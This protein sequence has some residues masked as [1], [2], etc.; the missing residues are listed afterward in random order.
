MT[1]MDKGLAAIFS[2]PW[3]FELI[4]QHASAVFAAAT[5]PFPI[6]AISTPDS[7]HVARTLID[8]A[9]LWA[10]DLRDATGWKASLAE[11]DKGKGLLGCFG[12]AELY[13]ASR[14]RAGQFIGDPPSPIDSPVEMTGFTVFQSATRTEIQQYPLLDGF[15]LPPEEVSKNPQR[16]WDLIRHELVLA[17]AVF[18]TR[19]L[20]LCAWVNERLTAYNEA[21]LPTLI[22]GGICGP[23]E[24]RELTISTLAGLLPPIHYEGKPGVPNGVYLA[25]KEWK[26]STIPASDRVLKLDKGVVSKLRKAVPM[27]HGLIEPASTGKKGKSFSVRASMDGHL[28]FPASS[29]AEKPV[30]RPEGR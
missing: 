1:R 21:L 20:Q 28:V 15:V 16:Y 17:Y 10:Q 25:F 22:F 11:S 9:C 14:W 30:D 7:D 12:S 13:S 3:Q 27:L 18:R 23:K 29:T 19:A 26:E 2:E 5:K 6:D 4:R 8:A 24:R